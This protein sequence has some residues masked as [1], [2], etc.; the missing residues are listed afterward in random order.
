LK[1]LEGIEGEEIKKAVYHSS[2]GNRDFYKLALVGDA[3]LNLYLVLKFY[4]KGNLEEIYA[5]ISEYKS[6]KAL[7]YAAEELNLKELLVANT[8]QVSDYIY[9]SMLEAITGLIYL[10]F[11]LEG[12]FKFLE[13][14]V[15]PALER[16]RGKFRNYWEELRKRERGK[17]RVSFY[18]ENGEFVAEIKIK[19]GVFLG[20]GKNKK[21]ARNEAAKNALLN[22]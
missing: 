11:G 15:F 19:D 17:I 22:K 1:F 13:E 20:R 3:V 9:A 10:K 2:L 14:E 6:N 18:E 5:M 21:E 12:A 8:N 7:Y 16:N 4:D